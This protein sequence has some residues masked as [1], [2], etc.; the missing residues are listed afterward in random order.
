MIVDPVKN[1]FIAD[2]ELRDTQVKV[3]REIVRDHGNQPAWDVLWE[4]SVTPWDLGDGEPQPG[5]K[6]FMQSSRGKDIT[7]SLLNAATAEKPA[8]A[9]VPGC[10]RGYDAAYLASLGFKTWGSDLSPTAIEQANL[11][12]Q[13]LPMLSDPNHKLAGNL[14][15]HVQ[16][17][18]KFDVPD[19]GFSLVYD[20]T[21]FCAIPPELRETWGK[22]MT[23]IIRPGG[24]LVALVFPID[25]PRNTGPPFS[26]SV[27]LEQGSLNK[28]GE[29]AWE[30]IQNEA[31]SKFA[32]GRE[33]RE[34]LCV[35]KRK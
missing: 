29:D 15:Y 12:A 31:P 27:E 13:S 9:L 34:R 21:F 20:Y 10:G 33:G 6:E 22:R 32:P 35:W 18:F 30:L 17:F 7:A 5:L 1:V 24:Y 3:F 14:S 11:W 19:D 28:A 8:R 4:K 25:G 26:I 23:E 16:D 2:D